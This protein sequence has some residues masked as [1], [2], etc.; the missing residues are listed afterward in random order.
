MQIHKDLSTL[1]AFRN[2]ALSIGSFDGVH[3][4]HQKIIQRLRQLAKEVNGESI[5]ITFHPHPRLLLYPDD[6]RLRL[7]NTVD[8]KV[9][10][11]RHY[12]VDHV[13]IVQFD[14]TFSQQS[15]EEYIE[16]FLI[17]KFNPSCI[18]I[19]YDHRFGRNRAGNIELLR[20]YAERNSIRIV[21]IEKQEVEDIAV[22]STKIRKALEG[23]DISNATHFQ[24]HYFSVTGTVVHGQKLGKSLG[25]PTANLQIGHR[26]KLIPKE[27]VYAVYVYHKEQRYDA[28]LYIG[29]RP[30]IEDHNKRSIEVNIFDFE[31][32][33]YSQELRIEFVAF[34][35]EDLQ[36]SGLE[37]LKAQLAKDKRSTLEVLKK[38]QAPEQK[39]AL[40]VPEVA[41]VILNYNGPKHLSQFLPS[42]KAST[43]TNFKIYVVDNGSTDNSIAVLEKEFPEVLIKALPQNYGFA[44]GYNQGLKGIE[45]D[46]YILLNSD[47]EVEPGWIEPI[48][49]LMESDATIGACQPKINAYQTKQYFEHAGASG[50]WMDQ[51]GY[52]FCRGRLFHVIEEDQGQY[53]SQME[54]FWASGAAMFVRPR[55]FQELGGFDGDFFA[56]LEEIDLCWRIK[57]AGYR[58]MAEP[59]SVV[60]HLGGGTLQYDNPQKTYLNF[61]NSLFTLL[62]NERLGKLLWLIPLRLI[63]D[64]VAGGLFLSQ[65]KISHIWAIIRA[66]GGFYANLG[67]MWR[68]RN[69]IDQIIEQLR[70]SPMTNR[71]GVLSGSLL[72]RFYIR[73]KKRFS[74]L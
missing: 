43:Y 73:R 26:H 71:K 37:A 54:V 11:L 14:E 62:K 46:Y 68:K 53:D 35:R 67:K 61:R 9:E 72:W 2:A 45:G 24:G 22:S 38:K 55:L 19:G 64:G 23:G 36:L 10:L 17:E 58:V 60:Y 20:S 40:E 52:P 57:R 13:V 16:Q 70:I 33:I 66:H 1:P 59:Q 48:I 29:Q 63:L 65:G 32:D 47:V 7:L 27:G 4:G 34:I 50:G 21:E 42:V 5:V 28:M 44:E 31:Q 56:H 30:T 74:E 51:L 3:K 8:E 49:K 41:I 6:Q 39:P 69:Q 25:F 18:V 12:G 15:P